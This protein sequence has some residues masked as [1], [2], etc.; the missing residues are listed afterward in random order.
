MPKVRQWYKIT[1]TTRSGNYYYYRRYPTEWDEE[2]VKEE[3]AILINGEHLRYNFTWAKI[4]VPPEDWIRDQIKRKQ[5]MI[6]DI[7]FEIDEYESLVP[8]TKW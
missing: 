1:V 8:T 6:D 5:K 3:I 2:T 4:D 7:R